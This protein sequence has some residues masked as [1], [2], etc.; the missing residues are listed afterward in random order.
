MNHYQISSFEVKE[1]AELK[2]W[3][4]IFV[5]NVEYENSS[6]AC[7][8]AKEMK[9]FPQRYIPYNYTFLVWSDSKLNVNYIGVNLTIRSWNKHT[10]VVARP[11]PYMCCGADLEFRE[12]MNQERYYKEKDNC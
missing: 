3:T 8:K 9:L 7:I 1:Q 5:S 10:A 6:M 11:H 12:S 4:S 2:N